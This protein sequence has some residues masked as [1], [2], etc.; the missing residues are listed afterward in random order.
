M[1]DAA[2]R[3]ILAEHGVQ[4][5]PSRGKLAPRWV[6]EAEALQADATSAGGGGEYDGGVTA[7]DF[8]PDELPDTPAA[9]P[10]SGVV[11]RRPKRVRAG[12]PSLADRLK[13]GTTGKGRGKRRGPAR[14]R[15]PVDRLI[16][17][18]W[19]VLARLAVPVSPPIARTLELQSPVAGL[20]LEDVV[21][22][23]AVDRALQPI[24]RAEEKA[25]KVLALVAPPVIV[26]ALQAAQGLPEDQRAMREALLVPMLRESLVLWIRIAGDKVEEKA[27]RESEMGPVNAKV[28]ELLAS[29]F[30]AAQPPPAQPD[31]MARVQEMAAV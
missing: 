23:T 19:E 17:R 22:G 1:D 27:A 8:P 3:A 7:A 11:E 4:G 30:T 25:E 26:G 12:R 20:I 28:D 16:E 10:S 18:G 29:I 6:S 24:A 2:A 31:D 13:A 15:V 21:R 14:P 5:V 9:P